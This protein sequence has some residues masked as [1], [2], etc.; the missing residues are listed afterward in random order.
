MSKYKHDKYSA[1][2]TARNHKFIRHMRVESVALGILMWVLAYT[3]HHSA[4]WILIL[5]PVFDIGMLG[6]VFSSKAGAF[7]YNLF[8]NYTIPTLMIAYG[9][10]FNASIISLLGIC[11]TFH[12]ALDRSLGYG[13]KHNHSFKKT[14]LGNIGM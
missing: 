9:V 6:Y 7:T 2:D 13:L 12:I 14:H 4:W 1:T 11:W 3:S 10:F 8:H 5:F